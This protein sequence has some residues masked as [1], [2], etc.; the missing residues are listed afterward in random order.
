[1][2][3]Q[4]KVTETIEQVPVQ[5]IKKVKKHKATVTFEVDEEF[6][7]VINFF[8][9]ASEGSFES[10]GGTSVQYQATYKIWAKIFESKELRKV[11]DFDY[12]SGFTMKPQ[13]Q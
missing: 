12:D 6:L 1:M 13:E 7:D 9:E 11:V 5:V 2:Q 4:T 8:G 3:I 10:I